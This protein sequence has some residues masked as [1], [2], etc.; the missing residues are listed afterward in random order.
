MPSCLRGATHCGDLRSLALAAAAAA[1]RFGL[2][3]RCTFLDGR[4]GHVERGLAGG[5]GRMS[6]WPSILPPAPNRSPRVVTNAPDRTIPTRPDG[7]WRSGWICVVGAR[8]WTLR[9]GLAS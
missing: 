1:H 2:I 4:P 3:V 5:Q 8:L 9:R 7:G 6:P